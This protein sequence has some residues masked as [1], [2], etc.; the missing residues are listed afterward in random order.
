LHK[1]K[2][3]KKL[4]KKLD[5]GLKKMFG[6]SDKM[7][8]HNSRRLA[9]KKLDDTVEQSRALIGRLQVG[10]MVFKKMKFIVLLFDRIVKKIDTFTQAKHYYLASSGKATRDK[11]PVKGLTL[12]K[13]AEDYEKKISHLN[14]ALDHIEKK[15]K[16]LAESGGKKVH[17]K[18]T[19]KANICYF[20]CPRKPTVT[21]HNTKKDKTPKVKPPTKKGPYVNVKK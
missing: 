18:V 10:D 14:L 9:M 19:T 1:E 15:A 8:L 4:D 12:H 13:K 11:Q 7:K 16:R 2:A 17:I 3:E 20:S 6:D 5:E 21:G